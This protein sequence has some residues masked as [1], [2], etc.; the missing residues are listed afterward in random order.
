MEA[1][2][3]SGVT[4]TQFE[5]AEKLIFARFFEKHQW[6]FLIFSLL[7]LDAIMVFLAFRW[8]Y[9]IRFIFSIPVFR[10]DV[11][12]SEKTYDLLMLVLVPIWLSCFGLFRLYNRQNILQGIRETSLLLKASSVAIFIVLAFEFLDVDL[13]I[14]RGWL[15]V[16]WLSTFIFAT[17]GRFVARR[18]VQI[19][20]RSGLFLTSA[21]IVGSNEEACLL[22]DQ[23]THQEF[24]GLKILGFVDNRLPLDTLVYDHL[25]T[26]GDFDHLESLVC[27][28]QVEEVILASSALNQDELLSIFQ[29]FGV[30]RGVNLRISSGLYEIIATGIQVREFSGVP[31]F[32]LHKVRL[33]GLEQAAKQLVD[34]SL[35]LPALILLLPVFAVLGILIRL[36]SPGPVIHRRRVMGVN[37]SQ[38][39]AFKFR[40]M[41]LNGDEI[42]KSNP[43]VAAEFEKNQ[44]L[45][46]DPRVTRIGRFLR[47]TSLDELPQV[48][49]VLRN[50]MSLIG[51][52]MISPE[53][54]K[55][56]QK[57]GLNLLTVK[58]GITGLWQV[59]GRS[60]ISYEKRV[61]MD[62]YY[63]RNWSIWMDL[64]ILLRTVPSVL[65]GKGAY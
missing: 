48:V 2:K 58:P 37:G 34:Y 50:E 17:M 45:R 61:Q 63:I 25:K 31:L 38:F 19:L 21:I 24:S 54:M 36:D 43:E 51:P 20:R 14:A 13:D 28:S 3:V 18:V 6:G 35:A 44:K 55:L 22:A 23:L 9:L 26:I 39:D 53:E 15:L 42:L 11:V 5:R 27:E 52:R 12:P 64:Q 1:Q 62:M 56:Y 29:R 65:F 49:N 30:S 59:S 40:T 7:V 57:A 47:K 4:G 46:I 10:L 8:S 33:T 16:S 32:G 41:Y 60:D